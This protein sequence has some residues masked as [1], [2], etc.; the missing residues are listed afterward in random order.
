MSLKIFHVFFILL[1]ALCTLGFAAWTMLAEQE[2]NTIG[3]QVAG[4]FSG[5]FGV[6]LLGYGYW[7]VAVKA[8][9]IIT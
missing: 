5:V 2:S 3:I 9:R 8:K 6:A 1:A 7:F 4:Y